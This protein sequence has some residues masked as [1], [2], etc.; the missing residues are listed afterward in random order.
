MSDSTND[1]SA[2]LT[3]PDQLFWTAVIFESSLGLTAIGLGAWLGPDARD[4]LP[5]WSAEAATSMVRSVGWGVAAAL[6]M[7]AMV[8]AI[9]RIPHPAVRRLEELGDE[10]AFQAVTRL[11]V[12]EMFAVSACAGVGEELLFRGWL[13]PAMLTWTPSDMPRLLAVGLALVGSSVAFGLVHP[14]TK[15]YA[16]M[17]T[18]FGLYLGGLMLWTDDLILP[19]V[20][21]AVYDWIQM[22]LAR[23]E[24]TRSP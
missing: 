9:R 1:D 2:D 20:A 10:A 18:I 11:G 17:A 12:A 5:Q 8:A 13:L 19:I 23:R 6:P 16:V 21:H 14:I 4:L 24:V 22:L 7:V 3:D 15:L